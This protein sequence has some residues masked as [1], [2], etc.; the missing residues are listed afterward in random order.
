MLHDQRGRVAD[1]GGGGDDA[2]EPSGVGAGGQQRA[3]ADLRLGRPRLAGPAEQPALPVVDGRGAQDLEL[4]DALDALG[5]DPGTHLA[6]ERDGGAK[7]GLAGGVEVDARDQPAAELEEVG[8][9]LGDV[10]ERR[11]ARA[12]VVHGHERAASDPGRQSLADARRV[13]DGVLLGELD[14]EPRRQSRREPLEAGVAERV[15]RDVDEQQAAVR[16]GAG[17]ADGRPARDLEV[18]A[19][20]AARGGG[21]RDVGR[22]RDQPGRRRKAGQPLVAD[23]LE[24]AEPDDRLI[25]GADGARLEQPAE[26]VGPVHPGG[27]GSASASLELRVRLGMPRRDDP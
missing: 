15:G 6:G 10:L 11:E 13:L 25:D 21:E 2:L 7:N 22:E 9:D 1:V 12:R 3:T 20:P 18:A 27:I 4:L 19:Q 14:H 16:R 5:H 17:V 26:V 24:V 23:R 8:P